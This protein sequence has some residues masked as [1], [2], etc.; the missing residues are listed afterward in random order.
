VPTV[1]EAGVPGYEASAWHA[2]LAPAGV[3]DEV[4]DTL[5]EA[6][7]EVLADPEVRARLERDGIEP[8][9]STPQE[10][11]AFLDREITKWQEVVQAAGIT[12]D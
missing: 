12:L 3:P 10:F 5:Y 8:I 4:V 9:G 11:A 6:I 1:S 7:R 2:V